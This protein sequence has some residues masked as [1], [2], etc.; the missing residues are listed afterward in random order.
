[1][2]EYIWIRGKMTRIE[3]GMRVSRLNTQLMD[4]AFSQNE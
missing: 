2:T 4:F 3:R 1:M